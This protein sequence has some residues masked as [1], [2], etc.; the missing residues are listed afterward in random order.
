[1]KKVLKFIGLLVVILVLGIWWFTNSLKPTYSGT[2]DIKNIQEEVSVYYDDYGIP[3]IYANNESD[4]FTA[5]GFVHAQD[6]LW[7]M[8]LLRRIPTGRL[9]ELFGEELVKTDRFFIG[10]GIDEASQETV[11][12]LDT[13]SKAYQLTQSYLNGINQFIE[14]GPKPLEFYLTGAKKQLFTIKD[15]YNVFGYMAFSFAM[16]HKT[17]PLL[18]NIKNKLGAAYLTDLAIDTN[19][20]SELIKNYSPKDSLMVSNILLAS[21]DEALNKLPVPQFIGSNSWVIA[22]Q[23]TSTGN[24]L[25][26]NDPHIGFAQ[27]SVWYEAHVHTPSYE[28]YGYHLA[29][30]PFP[31]LGHNRKIAYGMTMFENDDIDFYWE[32]NH[33]TDAN[34]YKTPEGWKSYET[35]TKTIKVKDGEDIIVTVK[36]SQHGSIMN[37]ITKEITFDQPVAMSWIY[38][39]HENRG[40]EAIYNMSHATNQNEFEA[41]MPLLH[42]P[43]LNIMYGDAENNIGWYAVGKLYELPE[44]SHSKFILDGTNG[45]NEPIRYLDF[46]E[47]P[48]ATNPPWHYVYSSNN[49]PDTISGRFYPGY[50]LPENRGKRIVQFLEPKNDWDKKAM[51]EMITDVKS[52]VNPTI[53]KELVSLIDHQN[54]N[55]NQKE[56]LAILQ[57]WNGDN[58]LQDIAPTIYHKLIYLCLKNTFYD[59][60]GDDM[61]AQLLKTHLIKRTIAPLFS[62]EN[63]VWFDNI[64]TENKSESRKDIVTQSYME[65]ISAL[66]NQ[67]GDNISQWTWNKVHTLEHQHPIG[68]VEALRSYFNVGPFDVNGTREVINNLGFNYNESGE[69]KVI[70]GPST[71]RIIDFS[72]IENSLSILPTGQ[73]GNVFS[74]HY[75]DQV[76]LYNKG[77]FR[78]MMLNEDEIKSTSKNVLIIK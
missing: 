52:S 12:K 13:T 16:A 11:I 39:Q 5:L 37:D 23:K 32:E 50:Y 27:P 66:E 35:R 31:I 76:E 43:G 46:S 73:S 71:R 59:E 55:K 60:L 3:H 36:T 42:A 58:Q 63:S 48:K 44:N 61:F 72:D 64:E 34:L 22:P 57:N 62:K 24:V 28:M 20:S 65:A 2:I 21:I 69:Y 41:A 10:L 78:K 38:T 26:A 75:K 15:V 18:T 74:P 45:E 17:D 77:E 67:L 51:T 40:L 49:Q 25:F 7:Q 33:P 19:P 53:A 29:A 68:K 56:A 70:S 9:A 4:A 8:E 54:L 47:N 1:M 30:S 6:R 14:E